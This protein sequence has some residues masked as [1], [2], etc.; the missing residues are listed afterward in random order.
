MKT[1]HFQH[2]VTNS[3]V[4]SIVDDALL[5]NGHLVIVAYMT[6]GNNQEDSIIFNKSSIDR[7]LFDITYYMYHIAELKYNE[8]IYSN[9]NEYN[10]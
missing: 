10:Y 1:L 3:P 7:G 4:R 8:S 6:Y 5:P 2:Y 9:N